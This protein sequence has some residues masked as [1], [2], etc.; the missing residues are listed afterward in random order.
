MLDPCV[1]A[2]VGDDETY[3]YELA[4]RL[5]DAGLGP[6]KGGSLYPSLARLEKHGFLASQWRAGDGGPGRK[7]YTLTDRG[8]SEL[9]EQSR[10]WAAFASRVSSVLDVEVHP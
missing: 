2:L 10:I 6:V 7:Y 8:R 4:G 1:L 9:R 5:G 3:G